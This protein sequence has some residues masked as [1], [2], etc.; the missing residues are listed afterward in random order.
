LRLK[1]HRFH[2][3]G[4]CKGPAHPPHV[5]QTLVDG[6]I[7]LMPLTGEHAAAELAVPLPHKDPFDELLLVQAQEEGCKLLARDA[8]LADHPLEVT[9]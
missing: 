8:R 7:P 6:G 5:L 2:V 3:S 4:E 1:W 9:G